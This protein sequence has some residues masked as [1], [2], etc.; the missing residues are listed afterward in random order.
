MEQLPS[1]K[2]HSVLAAITVASSDMNG[3][4]STGCVQARLARALGRR[5]AIVREFECAY[6][7]HIVGGPT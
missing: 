2:L 4:Q 3:A 6:G 1:R 7:F 5:R